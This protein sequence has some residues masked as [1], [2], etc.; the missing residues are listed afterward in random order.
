MKG[1]LERSKEQQMPIEII[2]LSEKWELTQRTVIVN[3]VREKYIKAF[4]F[5]KQQVRIFKLDN[6]LSAAKPKR[7]GQICLIIL[8]IH[9]KTAF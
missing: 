5:S 1:L 7:R 8:P 6:I 2:Y 3:E 4:C 9:K